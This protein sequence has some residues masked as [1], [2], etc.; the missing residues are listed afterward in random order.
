MSNTNRLV[1]VGGSTPTNLAVE[2]AD[3]DSNGV[4][5]SSW[6]TPSNND[7][8]PV[9]NRYLAVVEYNSLLYVSKNKYEQ[10][11]F[12]SWIKCELNIFLFFFVILNFKFTDFSR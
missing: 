2:F 5:T 8:L 3:V 12:F 7:I 11:Y 4:I 9:Y 1:I 10:I 6:Q